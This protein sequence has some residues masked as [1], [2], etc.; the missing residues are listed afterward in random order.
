M[1]SLLALAVLFAW[2]SSPAGGSLWELQQMITKVT[3]RN[4][5]LHYSFY[6]CYCGLGGHGEPKDATDRCCKLHDACYDSL[7]H[8]RCD[9]KVQ[10]YRYGWHGGSPACSRGSWCAQLSC[11]CDRSLGLCL[12]SSVRSY[13]RRYHLYPRHKCR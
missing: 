7:Q 9:A 8:H 12:K 5:L 13:S 10:R 2:G 4:A 1:N 3:G 11:E 6:G